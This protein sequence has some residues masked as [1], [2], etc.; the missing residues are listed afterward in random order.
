MLSPLEQVLLALLVVLAVGMGATLTV[1]AF[2]EVVRKPRGPLIGLASQFGWMPLIAFGLARTRSRCRRSSPSASSWWAARRGHHLE[3]VHLLCARRPGA[4]HHHDGA[5]VGGRGGAHAA[6]AACMRRPSR[7]RR[8]S[9]PTPTS[10]PRW[11]SCWCRWASAWPCVTAR[12]RRP[13]AWSG[14]AAWRGSPCWRC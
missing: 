10:P 14:P 8:W 3:P 9:S 11:R 7:A 1:D 2:R 4:E 5:L 6:R 12:R 13:R